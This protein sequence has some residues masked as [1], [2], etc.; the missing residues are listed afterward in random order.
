[1][2]KKALIRRHGAIMLLSVLMILRSNMSFA[3]FQDPHGL[4]DNTIARFK[5]VSDYTCRLDKRVKKNSILHEDLGISVKYKKPTHYY[6][7]WNQGMVKG[8]EVIFVAGR[9]NDKIVAHTGGI[10]RFFTWHL[11]PCGRLAMKRNRHSLQS[12]GMEKIISIIE[13]DYQRAQIMGIDA[14]QYIGEGSIEYDYRRSWNILAGCTI[15]KGDLWVSTLWL[16]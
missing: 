12:S 15:G 6:F 3:D 4:I 13:S 1:M 14:I 7:R 10:L 2:H 11:D 16:R 5:Q 8:R 9:H